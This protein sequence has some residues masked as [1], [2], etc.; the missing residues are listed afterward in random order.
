MAL[1]YLEARETAKA[2]TTTNEVSG[3]KVTEPQS[4]DAGPS[5]GK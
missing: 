4:D 3:E 2:K 1:S 5:E